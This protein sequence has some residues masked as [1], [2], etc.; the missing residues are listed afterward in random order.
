MRGIRPLL[1]VLLL[2]LLWTCSDDIDRTFSEADEQFVRFFMLVDN[3]NNVLEFP[4]VSGGLV[5]VSEYTKDR[6]GTLKIPVALSAINFDSPVN[7]SFSTE[8]SNNLQGISVT[9]QN[10]LSFSNTQLTDTIYV[11]FENS[12][13]GLNN[14]SIVFQLTDVSDSDIQIG[15][16]NTQ[17]PNDVLTINLSDVEFNYTL[18]SSLEEII[19]V[20]DEE[21]IIGINFPNGF[22]ESDIEGIDILSEIPS[23]NDLALDVDY[24]LEQ[25]SIDE[26]SSM[27]F[28]RYTVNETLNDELLYETKF[29]LADIPEY[30][31]SGI[32]E[33]TVRKPIV[34]FRDNSVNTAGN[35]YDLSDPFY[36]TFGENWMDFNEDG[37]C[38]WQA[39]NAFTFPVVVDANHPNAILFDDMGTADPS[40]DIY[41]HAFRVGFNS[42][43]AGNTTNSFNLKRWFNNE[44]SS[45]AN[46]PGF[47]IAE[48]LEFF[49]EDGTSTTNGFVQVIAQDLIIAG[50]NGNSYTIAI[51][52]SGTYQEI[53]PGI[54]EIDLEL[55]ATNQTL[56]G[57]TR[58]AN[59]L[60]YNT[61][62]FADP[63]DLSIPCF[64]PISL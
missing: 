48:A 40:D 32:T 53:S 17:S 41:H 55:Q 60:I 1:V 35:F 9:P 2:G 62:S 19:G 50:T 21:L 47:N 59:Y 29:Q 36:R 37:I 12:W 3:D 14:P 22:F 15:M 13:N 24:T 6:L 46:S 52:G 18:Q 23:E 11:N 30:E 4:E 45:D 8:V 31:M 56:F 38:S 26:A 49:P 43:N 34:T 25:V 7:V 27:V 42:P 16:P 5:P 39:F 61:P 64:I 51:E 44:S 28:Y 57:G 63:A 54:F 33:I 10:M 20:Q 58:I